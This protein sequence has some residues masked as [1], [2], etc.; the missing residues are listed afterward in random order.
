MNAPV[1]V[2]QLSG[3]AP[4]SSAPP[5]NLKLEKP[6]NGQAVTIH[7]DGNTRLDL[8]DI[9]SEK[10]TFVRVGEKLIVLFDNQSTV[11]VDPVFDSGGHPLADVAFDL[12]QNRLVTGDEFATLFPITTDQSVL[13]AAGGNSGPTGGANFSDAHVNALT[14]PNAPL[15]L[16]GDEN[17]GSQ[18]GSQAQ[19]DGGTPIVSELFANAG[20]N[21]ANLTGGTAENVGLTTVTGS[22]GVN[23][24]TAASSAVLSFNDGQ[25]SL[26]TLR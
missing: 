14:D 18:F 5:K 20:L 16:L 7:L 2:A 9:S 17:N 23:F 4:Q 1:L 10:L 19:T 3:S 12:G 26:A 22:L 6:Q 21:E 25:V 15:A 11:T 13:P 8:S 24:G